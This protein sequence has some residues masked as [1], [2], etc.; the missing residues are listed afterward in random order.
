MTDLYI[1]SLVKVQV[2]KKNSKEVLEIK[3]SDNVRTLHD[4]Q[5]LWLMPLTEEKQQNIQI[6]GKMYV[7]QQGRL[8]KESRG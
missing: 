1:F 2:I 3:R 6:K 8:I 5:R 4:I 7:F